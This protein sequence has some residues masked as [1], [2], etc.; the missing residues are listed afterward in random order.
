MEL[1]ISSAPL[2][3]HPNWR[4]NSKLLNKFHGPRSSP[5]LKPRFRDSLRIFASASI[6]DAQ[7]TSTDSS[8]VNPIYKPTPPNRELRTPHSGYPF[9]AIV[10][11]SP[12]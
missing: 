8:S 2:T 9:S 4:L 5:H 3:S 1:P 10:F 6:R 12:N 11:L 7:S